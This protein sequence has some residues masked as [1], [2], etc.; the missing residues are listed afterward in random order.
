MNG[1]SHL[2]FFLTSAIAAALSFACFFALALALE[3]GRTC[4]RKTIQVI[5]TKVHMLSS[6]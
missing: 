6:T 2:D 5:H 1:C 3:T 4:R